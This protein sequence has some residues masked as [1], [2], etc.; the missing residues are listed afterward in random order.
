[1]AASYCPVTDDEDGI[2]DGMSSPLNRPKPG[3]SNQSRPQHTDTLSVLI[4]VSV[5]VAGCLQKIL[6]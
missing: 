6:L 3:H 5:A 4:S 2:K 1:M